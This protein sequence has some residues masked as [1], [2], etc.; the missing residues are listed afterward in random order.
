MELLGFKW[1]WTLS[2]NRFHRALLAI[3]VLFPAPLLSGGDS[4]TAE[5]W[6]RCQ[7]S[8]LEGFPLQRYPEFA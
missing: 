4:L 6:W 8:N 7:G 1:S 5:S 3:V 2:A